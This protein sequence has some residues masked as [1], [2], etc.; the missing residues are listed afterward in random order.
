[1]KKINENL[2]SEYILQ[3]DALILRKTMM[4]IDMK[5]Y[6]SKLFQHII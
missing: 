2:Q 4:N 3:K 1:M 6:R 5:K